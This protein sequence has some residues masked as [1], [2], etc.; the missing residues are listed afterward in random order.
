M[1]E[2]I[3]YPP[4][5]A[6]SRVCIEE[7]SGEGYS[8]LIRPSPGREGTPSRHP[9]PSTPSAPRFLCRSSTPSKLLSKTKIGTPPHFLKQSYGLVSLSQLNCKAVPQLGVCSSRKKNIC[10]SFRSYRV[11][12]HPNNQTARQTDK[13]TLVK[14]IP[15]SLG[16]GLQP[17][18]W[19]PS[20]TDWDGGI[21]V[22]LHCGPDCSL[23]WAMD[24]CIMWR[25]SISSCQSAA[26]S[27]NVKRCWSW[28]YSHKHINRINQIKIYIA[29][30]VHEDSEVLGGWITCSRRVGID[31]FLNVF[32]K[33]VNC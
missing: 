8:L 29:P 27:K 28:V 22:V 26:T 16:Y 33:T 15:P 13:W 11:D 21:S 19:R 6:F 32:W 23:S 17:L 31:E 10:L 30:Y 9:T 3:R 7:F 18:G 1:S 4:K 24:G 25:S 2:C 14:I 12:T 20:V 5:C